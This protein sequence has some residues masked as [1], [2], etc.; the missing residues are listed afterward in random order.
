M[1]SKEAKPKCVK[2]YCVR[3]KICDT[4]FAEWLNTEFT[5]GQLGEQE[6]ELTKRLIASG[7]FSVRVDRFPRIVVV[8]RENLR[9]GD[10]MSR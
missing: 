8:D 1:A 7:N 4:Y 9:A 5:L 6:I 10:L 3:S 2:L